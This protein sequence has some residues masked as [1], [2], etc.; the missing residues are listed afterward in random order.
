MDEYKWNLILFDENLPRKYKIPLQ[1][2]T[3]TGHFTWRPPLKFSLLSWSNFTIKA[4]LCNIQYFYIVDIRECSSKYTHSELVHFALQQWLR[5]CAIM[6]GF[7]YT[8]YII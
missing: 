8:T 5:E 2:T 1:H 3:N 7:M 4:P 6:L